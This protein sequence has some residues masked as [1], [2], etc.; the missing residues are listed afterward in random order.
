MELEHIHYISTS[1]VYPAT[2]KHSTQAPRMDL[3]PWDLQLLPV[4][5]IQK[6]LLFLKPAPDTPKDQSLIHHLETSLSRALDAFFPLA[7][8]LSVV[9]NNDNTVTYFIN[10]NNTGAQL[11]HATTD[12]MTVANILEPRNVPSIVRPFFPLNSL[13]NHQ[14][15]S[16]NPSL[17]HF[18]ST[19]CLKRWFVDETHFP[20]HLFPPVFDEEIAD[21]F[22]RTPF[23]QERVLKLNPPLPA[24]YFGNAL[25]PVAVTVTVNELISNGVGWI[26]LK[27]RQMN[28]DSSE[29][30]SV[31]EYL[32]TR[33]EDHKFIRVRKVG[34]NNGFVTVRQDSMFMGTTFVG[35]SLLLCEVG[36]GINSMGDKIEALEQD[37]EFMQ[38][39]SEVPC[40]NYHGWFA[41]IQCLR[42]RSGV[43]NQF[44]GR[45]S[46]YGGVEDGIMDIEA[47]LL[48]DK[49]QA[50]EKDEELF[51]QTVS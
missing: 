46:V 44:D 32:Q 47:R 43:G 5:Y 33:L 35:D 28:D 27:M 37:E 42:V 36:L 23:L 40:Q 19:P 29:E 18:V 34:S 51:M 4:D 50:L 39:V 31:R 9:Q 11:I 22:S 13:K 49:F 14:D 48:G 3:S 10:C 30:K 1:T 6:G 38:I 21:A 16:S 7:G 17:N 2:Y 15:I 24:H 26:A 20:V 8:R 25:Q 45:L 41:E 12:N